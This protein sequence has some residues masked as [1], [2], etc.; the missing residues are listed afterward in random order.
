[1]TMPD[2]PPTRLSYDLVDVFTLPPNIPFTGNPLAVVY[3]A[4][5]LSQ[6]QL[7]TIA[8]RASSVP[9]AHRW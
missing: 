5:D 7:Q 4:Q 9:Y 3:G 8:T 6:A 1:M 2:A